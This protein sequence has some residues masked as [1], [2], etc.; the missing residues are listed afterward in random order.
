MRRRLYRPVS[1]PG[2]C[3]DLGGV[4]DD[5]DVRLRLIPLPEQLRRLVVRDGAG[6]DHVFSRLPLRRGGHLVARG[7]LQRV[8]HPQ[9]LVEVAAG[10]HR[11]DEDQLDLLV[12]PDH[13][14]V[15][16]RLVVGGRASLR[17]A[18]DAGG[19]HPVQLRD[20]QIRVA[21]E[22]I[23]GRRALCLLDVL[24][25]L[26]VIL[27]R[28]DR[29]ADDL[30]VALVELRLDARHVAELGRAHRREVLRVREEHAP[31]VAEPLVKVDRALRR[32][33][34]EVRR[35]VADR[36]FHSLPPFLA[37]LTVA[38]RASQRQRPGA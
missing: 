16:H 23:I 26:R 28:V 9:H 38:S 29:E 24:G 20:R 1:A 21:D 14:D 27:G 25:P 22:R 36:Q 19:Q 37:T 12:G 15:A 33:G 7:Q 8:D 3:G 6:D 32:L 4:R 13:E 17:L 35:G 30:H 2:A 34:L 10:R 31:G 11:I 18:V 5:P